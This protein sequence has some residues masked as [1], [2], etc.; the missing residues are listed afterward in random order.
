M[1]RA[2]TPS[3]SPGVPGRTDEPP[4]LSPADWPLAVGQGLLLTWLYQWEVLAAC[5]HAL[6]VSQRDYHDW[7]V[8]RFGGGVPLDG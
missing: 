2:T 8:C 4:A 7:W 5:Q 3:A 1:Q 6:Q